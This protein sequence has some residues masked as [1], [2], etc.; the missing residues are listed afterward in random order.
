MGMVPEPV[1]RVYH[2]NKGEFVSLLKASVLAESQFEMLPELID[3]FGDDAVKFLEIFSGR[4]VIVPPIRDLLAKM[5]Q[6]SVWMA[7]G[8]ARRA[9]LRGEEAIASVANRLSVKKTEVRTIG[10]NMSKLM[11]QLS[12]ELR[13]GNGEE[14]ENNQEEGQEE[15]VD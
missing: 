4:V 11:D 13:P 12:M 15:E 8:A 5:K 7:L 1:L 6:V 10:K 14:E 2:R 3:I 9:G